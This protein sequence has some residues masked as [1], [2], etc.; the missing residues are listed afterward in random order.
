MVTDKVADLIIRIKNAGM[1]KKGTVLVPYS[2]FKHQIANKLLE[3]GYLSSVERVGSKPHFNLLLTISYNNG[4]LSF[5][6]V[7]RVSTPGKR[8]YFR[9]QDI[10]PIKNG[11]GVLVLSTP[12]GI[13][14]GEEARKERV[15]GESL[16][17]IW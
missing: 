4:D 15:G 3:R 12:K 8:T 6:D 7:K 10:R 17:V 9:V 1:V 14:T 2:K 5:T 13:L 11:R 16:F